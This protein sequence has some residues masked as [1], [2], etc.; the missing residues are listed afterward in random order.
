MPLSGKGDLVVSSH[1]CQG[2]GVYAFSCL[3]TDRSCKSKDS[4]GEDT[5][6]CHT[7]GTLPLSCA[8]HTNT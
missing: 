3:E 2:L 4:L 6:Y 1:S 7:V 8:I 5:G